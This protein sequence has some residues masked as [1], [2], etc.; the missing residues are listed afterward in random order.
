MSSLLISVPCYKT[1]EESK[2]RFM[3]LCSGLESLGVLA[4][5][6]FIIDGKDA[7]LVER[8]RLWADAASACDGVNIRVISGEHKLGQHYTTYLGW[9]FTDN[10]YDFYL[11]LDDDFKV[12]TS[13]LI[14]WIERITNKEY[15][16]PM[17]WYGIA[18]NRKVF[19][20]RSNLLFWGARIFGTHAL[21]FHPSSIRIFNAKGYKK[22]QRAGDEYFWLIEE[23]VWKSFHQKS[24]IPN[25]IKYESFS[26]N[27]SRTRY[28]L[29]SKCWIIA[30]H[31]YHYSWIY[32]VLLIVIMLLGGK[33]VK[34][35]ILTLILFHLIS[36]SLSVGDFL[37]MRDLIKKGTK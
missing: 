26:D 9:G 14:S 7:E 24:I 23:L 16:E 36:K 1:H 5:F 33:A 31:L 13:S 15:N 37:K 11:S 4:E 18:E 12:H 20:Y 29:F 28:S 2:E 21:T 10:E 19:S 8:L 6:V 3:D 27:L 17:I 30:E 32:P 25:H 34:I 35:S 22:I